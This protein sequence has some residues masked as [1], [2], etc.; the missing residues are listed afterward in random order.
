MAFAPSSW[1]F[2]HRVIAKVGTGAGDD[3]KTIQALSSILATQQNEI[4][5]GSGLADS[6]K[7]YNVYAELVRASDLHGVENFYNNP[8][9]PEDLLLAQNEQLKKAVEQLQQQIQENPLADAEKIR[10]EASLL[11]AQSRK[12]EANQKDQISVAKMRQDMQ[13]FLL[14]LRQSGEQFDQNIIKDLT[15]LELKYGQDVPGST[16]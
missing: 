5:L 4:Q 7:K 14:N 15:E 11:V 1:K 10:A 8:E 3:D 13:Q 2:D 16:V 9:Q 12:Q 6:K